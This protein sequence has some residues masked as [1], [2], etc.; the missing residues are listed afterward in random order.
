MTSRILFHESYTLLHDGSDG[1]QSRRFLRIAFSVP[2]GC[3]GIS[4]TVGRSSVFSAQIPVILFDSQG[5]IRLMRIS[6]GTIGDTE[7]VS[8]VGIREAGPGGIPGPLPAGEWHLLLYKRRFS[9]D[10]PVTV[11]VSAAFETDGAGFSSSNI[12]PGNLT[13]AGDRYGNAPGWYSGELHVHSNESTGR[14]DVA[15]IY[16]AA[17][18]ENLDFVALTDHFT[19]A[20]WLRIEELRRQGPP[21]FIQSMEVSGDF[22][23][24]NVHGLRTWVNPLVDDNRELAEFLGLETPP[25]M[26]GI[27]DEAH[28]Q[29]GLFCINHPLS[30]LVAWRYH[31]FPLEKADL[32]EIWCLPDRE[33]AFLYPTLWDGFLCRGIRLTGIGSS[34][35][36]H[37][38]QEGPWK[39]GQIRNWV[40][41]ESLCREDILRGL[42]RGASYI[43]MGT[44]RLRFV[45]RSGGQEYGMGDTL[46]LAPGQECTFTAELNTPCSGNLFIF[47]DGMIHDIIYF[48]S[49]DFG[50]TKTHSFSAGP[51]AVRNAVTGSSYFRI[52][53][54]EDLVK[55]QF[56]GMAHR[57]HRTMRLISN[58]IWI[59]KT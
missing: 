24:A 13:F 16:E 57:D 7:D 8:L 35:S 55:S 15:E 49:A 18:R 58:P 39:L 44:S 47:T 26:E 27:A 11:D 14:T 32:L 21:L 53:F 33:T 41:A 31:D 3:S 28:R 48:G 38:T 56:Y 30:G 43:A 36:H 34:D 29:G 10:I 23:H 1:A 37:P 19:A 5:T 22:G 25:S 40:Y 6:E 9:E 52:E 59:K 42:K 50:E 46:E 54:H 20:H 2:R 12:F 4:V 17:R 51:E 45:C